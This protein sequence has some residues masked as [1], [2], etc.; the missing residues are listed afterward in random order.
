MAAEVTEP[1]FAV[2]GLPLASLDFTI[3]QKHVWHTPWVTELFSIGA[4]CPI[5]R[6]H[7][8]HC[9]IIASPRPGEVPATNVELDFRPCNQV[10]PTV[11]ARIWG[12][13]PSGVG[14]PGCNGFRYAY[15]PG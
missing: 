2:S 5:R 3:L 8:A 11:L 12:P 7:H 13:S 1:P 4:R 6:P 14:S 9:R 10:L 15:R